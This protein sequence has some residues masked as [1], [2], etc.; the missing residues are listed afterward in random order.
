MFEIVTVLFHGTGARRRQSIEKNGLLPKPESYVCASPKRVIAAVF[1]TARAE[2][3]DDWGLIVALLKRGDWEVD[4]RFPYSLRCKEAVP[5][6]DIVSFEILD[7]E[8]EIEAHG[9]LKEIVQALK[10]RVEKMGG[11]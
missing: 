1:A 7:P 4:P 5:P 2:Q 10:I 6:S 3:E 11:V 8:T 9:H